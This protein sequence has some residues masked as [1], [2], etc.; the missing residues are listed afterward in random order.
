MCKESL[1]LFNEGYSETNPQQTKEKKEKNEDISIYSKGGTLDVGKNGGPS[2]PNTSL[3]AVKDILHFFCLDIE[4][5]DVIF[6]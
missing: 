4:I 6:L 5:V 3:Y 1:A 2:R